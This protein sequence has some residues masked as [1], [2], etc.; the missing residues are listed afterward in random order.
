MWAPC[1][2]LFVWALISN[3]YTSWVYLLSSTIKD[4]TSHIFQKCSQLVGERVKFG[5]SNFWDFWEEPK[6]TV[7][8][9]RSIRLILRV[10]LPAFIHNQ[11][12]S[13]SH[14]FLK[15]SQL[16]GEWVKLGVSNFWD[17]WEEP[18]V[19]VRLLRSIRLILGVNQR[20]LGTS[21]TIASWGCFRVVMWSAPALPKVVGEELTNN[22]P[23]SYQRWRLTQ[24]F[25]ILMED[26][27]V[28]EI[29]S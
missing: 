26:Q 18:K 19:K 1:G 13:I 10:S 23:T 7:R 2:L 20:V 3:L 8:L 24:S 11:G 9:L 28:K 6:V 17:F 21:R 14:I 4:D 22:N 25:L 29:A 12:W 15:C 16:A 27:H 5:V